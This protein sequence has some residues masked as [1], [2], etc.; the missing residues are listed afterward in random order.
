MLGRD[1]IKSTIFKVISGK[2]NIKFI[3]Q[4]WGH[5]V[6]LC[7]HGACTMAKKGKKMKKIIQFYFPGTKI[8]K[9]KG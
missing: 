3:G 2:Q 1:H 8:V 4:G 5:G 6:G 7:Q 9:L